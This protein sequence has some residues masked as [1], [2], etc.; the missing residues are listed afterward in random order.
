[1]RSTVP[2]KLPIKSRQL[3]CIKSKQERLAVIKERR[4]FT[5]NQRRNTIKKFKLIKKVNSEKFWILN[6][7]NNITQIKKEISVLRKKHGIEKYNKYIKMYYYNNITSFEDIKKYLT[8]IY[9]QEHNAFKLQIAFGYVCENL[10]NE[11]RLFE[12]S[13]QF[14]F[15]DYRLIKNKQDLNNT[16]HYL[17]SDEIN[18]KISLE[19]PDSSTRLVG[20]YAMGVKII[21]LDYPVGSNI[22]LPE[23][24]KSSMFIISLDKVENNL[25]AWA[26]FAIINGARRDRYMKQAKELFAS[27]YSL[28]K[29][30]IE[31]EISRYIGFDYINELD[32]YEASSKYAINIICYNEDKSI[33]YIRKSKMNDTRDPKYLNLF[34]TH[35][36]VVTDL[37]KLAK[38]YVCDKCGYRFDNNRNLDKHSAT[39]KIEH[40]DSFNSKSDIWQC[41]RNTIVEL[42]EY[43]DVVVDFKYDY[44]VAFDLESILLKIYEN[45][46]KK[47]KYVTRHVP[48]SVSIATNVPG[49]DKEEKFMSS[50]V[51]RDLTR[52]MFLYFDEVSKCAK[53][54]MCLKMKPLVDKISEHT[55]EKRRKEYLNKVEEYCSCIPIVGFN[56][57]FYDTCLLL[58]EGFMLEILQRDKKP[59]IMK[60]ANRYKCIKTTQFLFLDQMSYCAAGVSLDKFITAYDVGEVKGKFPYEW[61]DS[62]DKLDYLISDLKV[63]DFD[64][65]LK[66]TK[67]SL[68]EYKTFM[69]ICEENGLIYI[70]DLLQWYNNLDVRPML[71]ACLKQKE[72][73][74]TFKLDMYKD[75]TSLPALSENIMFQ[76][77]IKDF[78]KFLKDKTKP[79]RIET[80]Y[81]SNIKERIEGYIRQDTDAK[82]SLENYIE[83]SDV[84]NLLI[85]EQY[86]CHY[87][88][89]PVSYNYKNLWTLDRID[90][91]KSHTKDNCVIACLTCNK[92]RSDELYVKFYRQKALERYDKLYPL[93]RI[94]N[95]ENNEVFY[96]LKKNIVGGASIVYHRYH[97]KDV[98]QITRVH[99]NQ[100]DKVWTY[101]EVGKIVKKIC[102][103][104]A[105]AL[106]LYCLGLDMPCGELKW[107]PTDSIQYYSNKDINYFKENFFGF[108][109]V[110]I[111]VPEDKYEYFCEMCPIFKNVKYDESVCGE[112]TKNLVLKIK[113]KF[114][115]SKKLIGTLQATQI[116]LSSDSLKWLVEHGCIVTKLYGVIPAIPRK[117]FKGFVDWVSDERRK[118]DEDTKYS[119]VADCAKTVGNSAFGRTIMNKNK[120]K[121]TQFCDE[122]KFNKLKCKPTFYDATE[123]NGV[124]EV[125]QKKKKIK[126]NMA[127]QIGCSVFLY[128]KLRMLQFYYD[129]IDKYLDRSDFQYIEMDTDSAYMALSDD[130]ENLIK[131]GLRNE[132][133]R[134]KVNWFPRMDTVEHKMYDKRKPGLFKIEFE[135]DGMIALCSKSYYVFGVKNKCSSK[136]V[137][138]NNNIEILN[139]Y[140]YL[141]CLQSREQV[142]ANNKGF[143]FTE[144]MIKTY[145]QNKIGLS[146][147]YTKGRLFED[148]IHICPLII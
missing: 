54:L 4:K 46:G 130:F 148:G 116:L 79:C 64:S 56:S 82:R 113:N 127:L 128:S 44:L 111:H 134:D 27:F 121:K 60:A 91:S 92:Q 41:K 72:F 88:W 136:G 58:N 36:S 10:S 38:Y 109:E 126:Q 93:I 122:K 30:Q 17:T 119:I 101:D 15:D 14:Y 63:Q 120:H 37:F 53:E 2:A 12:P 83:I 124:Y 95:N 105:N 110:D 135:G 62:Y 137:Q 19:F 103:F 16:F 6:P 13:Q 140:T 86:S 70:K 34:E 75:A 98:T 11:V 104:D 28:D 117:I 107:I 77:S 132:F 85:K 65:S 24:I 125:I 96:K 131:P 66:N 69:C 7:S 102:G 18:N 42:T 61:L 90:C 80:I 118:G 144:K 141:R 48:I 87:C 22:Q 39:C 68:E 106:Y 23:Y 84:R 139:K 138:Q 26:C 129:C 59:F 29:K 33:K 31:A 76:F 35:L 100:Q 50:T 25:C 49:Y 133:E 146:P 145:E 89:Q 5:K 142:E 143:R 115:E 1:M 94:I 43:F 20:V 3:K 51:P 114:T 67:L 55:N 47:L 32:K 123:Y 97:E 147:I 40:T 108:L 112:Y 57:S 21:R 99:C 81:N 78:D 8:D 45:A 9:M 71:K 52:Q 73:F 74:Y